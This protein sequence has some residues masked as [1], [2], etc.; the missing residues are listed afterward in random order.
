MQ[1]F[2]FLIACLASCV[3]SPIHRSRIL[4][5]ARQAS[6]TLHLS[7]GN[8]SQTQNVTSA[9]GNLTRSETPH[10]PLTLRIGLWQMEFRNYSDDA[11]SYMLAPGLTAEFATQLRDRFEQIRTESHAS[12]HDEYPTASFCYGFNGQSAHYLAFFTFR[13]TRATKWHDVLN[14]IDLFD[15]WQHAW[16]NHPVP[17]FDY[18]C[19]FSIA[20]EYEERGQGLFSVRRGQTEEY[21]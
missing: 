9:I 12:L 1:V 20:G 16:N 14:A 17:G 19:G 7:Y 18:S 13:A 21:S 11:T 8:P 5:N 3:A 4:L 15:E 10:D 6:S 2:V